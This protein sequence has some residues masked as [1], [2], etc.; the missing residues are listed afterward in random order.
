MLSTWT[1]PGCKRVWAV[2]AHEE[3]CTGV[4]WHP[5]AASEAV[6]EGVVAGG[7]DAQ[8]SS[9]GV[10]A[11]AT[12]SADCTARLWSPAGKL[13]RALSGHTDRL[14]RCAFHPFGRQL[15]TA[16]FDLTWRW[17]DVETGACLL[18]QEGHS[19]PVY[20]LAHHPDGSLLVSAG[21]DAY[22]RVWDLRTGR[23]VLTLQ[24]HVKQV[25][26]VDCSANGVSVATGSEDNT[27]RVWDLRRKGQA[28]YTIPAHTSLVSA[29]RY[30]PGTGAT[31]MSAGY[32]KVVKVWC[33]RSH[34][35]LAVLA[36][37][38]GR[39]MHADVS[40]DG[41]HTVASVSYDRTLKFWAPD[42]APAADVLLFGGG[43]S[44]EAAP[45]DGGGGGAVAM[46]E[47]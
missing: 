44:R 20:A 13:L 40:P 19:R 37:H 18:E 35:M 30:Q 45:A 34:K 2:R 4:A 24:G 39:V 47:Q 38:E 33:G 27:V 42:E 10:V 22:G 28:V 43:N 17:W 46:D 26:A 3:R 14:A 29:V 11:L 36:G 32:D 7:S 25:L 41:S 5:H 21:L 9:S 23:C 15:A 6:L 16:S 1:A 31:L 8:P 12:A